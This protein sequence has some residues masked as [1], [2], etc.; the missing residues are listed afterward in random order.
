MTLMQ[1]DYGNQKAPVLRMVRKIENKIFFEEH[2]SPNKSIDFYVKVNHFK[3]FEYS[4]GCRNV[5]SR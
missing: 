5:K 2:F 4:K 1:F 3:H